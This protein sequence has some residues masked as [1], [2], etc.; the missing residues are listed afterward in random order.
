MTV[1]G[2]GTASDPY[3]YN[4]HTNA[5]SYGMPWMFYIMVIIVLGL[6]A[7]GGFLLGFYFGKRRK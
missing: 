7:T 3:T 5:Q 4:F 1:S 2:S 6:A